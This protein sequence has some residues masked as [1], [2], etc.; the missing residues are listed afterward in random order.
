MNAQFHK[1]CNPLLPEAAAIFEYLKTLNQARWYTNRGTLQA[2][3][4]ERL[5]ML[6][7]ADH[8][9]VVATAS[10]SAA[11]E[12]SI[13]ATA[14]TATPDK[15]YAFLPSYTFA[16]TALAA[17]RCG[18]TPYFLDVDPETWSLDPDMIARHPKIINAGVIIVVAP[19]G[20]MPDMVAL[21]TLYKKT[22]VAVVV[23]AAAAFEQVV[24]APGCI[25]ATIPVCL[26][27]HATK[28]FSTGEGGAVLWSD[29]IGRESIV[30]ATNFGFLNSRECRSAG[31]NGKMSE[32]SAAV[33]LA[34]L[35]MLEE[36]RQEYFEVSH[37]YR[38]AFAS[39]GANSSGQFFAS[40]EISSAYALILAR[41]SIVAA[42]LCVELQVSQFGW[43]RWYESGLHN[44]AHFLDCPRDAMAVTT[45]LG[46]RLIGLPMAH[47][48]SEDKIAQIV[49]VVA[50]TCETEV[51]F[52]AE[53]AG[54]R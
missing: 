32:Y 42:E 34:M 23:D 43:R 22:G 50:A 46:D 21:E 6:F 7:G 37:T 8:N 28:T 5:S 44:M 39:S 16:A 38:Q 10:G 15:P 17:E 35:D 9:V 2:S 11:L 27:F 40:P 33:G 45:D 4:E 26:S 24:A 12:A 47:D 51:A 14:G 18:Y 53:Q 31:F 36:R 25:S 48:L 54:G 3:L 1:V 49:D 41:D 20:R 29:Q 30:Q 13:L 19:Y 52:V